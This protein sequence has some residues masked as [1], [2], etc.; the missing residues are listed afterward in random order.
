[1]GQPEFKLKLGVNMK[2]KYIM[3]KSPNTAPARFYRVGI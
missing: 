2:T 3:T 1:M